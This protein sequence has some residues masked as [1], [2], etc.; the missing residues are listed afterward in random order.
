MEGVV[1]V[2]QVAKNVDADTPAR[3]TPAKFAKKS[4]GPLHLL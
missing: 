4:R 1:K 2:K 3:I